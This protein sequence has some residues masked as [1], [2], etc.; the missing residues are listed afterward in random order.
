MPQVTILRDT[1]VVS[2]SVMVE[3]HTHTRHFVGMIII[4][5]SFLDAALGMPFE[6][7]LN[8]A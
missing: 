2:S 7:Q 1:Y 3:L 8:V 5:G 6:L 4:L